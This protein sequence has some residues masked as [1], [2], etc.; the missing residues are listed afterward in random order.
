M[1]AR[2]SPLRPWR[3]IT[4]KEAKARMIASA[5]KISAAAN[6]ASAGAISNRPERTM[7]TDNTATTS[8]NSAKRPDQVASL[9]LGSSPNTARR[10]MFVSPRKYV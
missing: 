10:T 2:P 8:P 1:S 7:M 4:T 9:D 5:A 3:Q 6:V